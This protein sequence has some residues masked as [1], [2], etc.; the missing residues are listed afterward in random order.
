MLDDLAEVAHD[1]LELRRVL[2]RHRCE[3]PA[4]RLDENADADEL[5]ADVVVEVEA[6]TL[7]LLLANAHLPPGEEAELLLAAPQIRKRL[8]ECVFRLVTLGDVLDL[9]DE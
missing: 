2:G 5:L 8:P 1:A 9:P 3:L 4:Q 6:E 7:A